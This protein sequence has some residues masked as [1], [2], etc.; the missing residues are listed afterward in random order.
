MKAIVVKELSE[1]IN[2]IKYI[3][4]YPEPKLSKD[5]DVLVQVAAAGCNF[6]DILMIKGTYQIKQ[7]A[8]FILGTEFSGIV[9]DTKGKSN[10]KKGD[11]VFGCGLGA[12]AEKVVVSSEMVIPMPTNISFEEAAGIFI[13][14]PTSLAALKLRANLQPGQTI[15]VHGASGGV[16]IAAVQMAKLLGAKVI[17]T[18]TD[19]TK[20]QIVKQLGAE[21]I[22]LKTAGESWKTQVLDLT[23]KKGVDVVY[24][25]V[26]LVN[27][28][29]KCL[30]FGGKVVVVGFAGGNHEQVASNRILLKNISVVGLH[31]GAYTKF[32]QGSILPIWKQLLTW[33]SS[34][35]LK[36]VI[37]PTIYKIEDTSK[38]IKLL[39]DRK[40][41]GK[42]VVK[43]D[44]PFNSQKGNTMPGSKL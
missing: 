3:N 30:K 7:K 5:G 35:Q 11:K 27:E 14:Y 25:P 26:G 39:K 8:P 10:F 28:S 31:W 23:N 24:D 36:P 1:D 22:N 42:V 38:A 21:I 6:Y 37:F 4:D 34:K 19:D 32:E 40:A 17:A 13:T 41:Y 18:G 2:S 33:L 15:L 12:Y 44:Q 9:L 29:I 16:G 20:L 43:L